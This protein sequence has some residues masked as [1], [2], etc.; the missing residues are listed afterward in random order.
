MEN[1]KQYPTVLTI[2][3]SDSGG[4]AGIQADIK[5]I[6]ANGGYAASV[7]TA[8]TAQNTQGVQGIHAIPVSFLK[9]QLE[10]VFSDIEFKAVKIGMLHSAEVISTVKEALV[11]YNVKNVVLDPVMVATS[12]DPLLQQEAI[13]ALKSELLP[14]A[15]LITP[16]LP[17]A[18][19]LLGKEIQQQSEL[20]TYAQHLAENFKTSVL[21]KAG[22]FEEAT[23]TDALFN[24]ET[25]EHTIFEN[26]RIATQNTHG[27]G[28][29]LSSAIATYLAQNF[30][31]EEAIL[32]A[33]TYLHQA[34]EYGKNYQLGK[35]HGPV[36]HFYNF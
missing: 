7:I 26:Q 23:L 2:A 14:L 21:L 3:G 6:S 29:T 12:G 17:E 4:G 31:L 16:N 8:L 1:I 32:K 22:H 33:T 25:K 19:L 36:N 15:T 27:T 11:T 13:E 30:T 34:L 35:G 24:L 20:K 5:S 18:S 10:S 28:C 9:Q